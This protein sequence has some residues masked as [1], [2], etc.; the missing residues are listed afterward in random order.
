VAAAFTGSAAV[1]VARLSAV[2]VNVVSCPFMTAV[3]VDVTVDPTRK[4]EKLTFGT[5]LYAAVNTV[6]LVVGIIVN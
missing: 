3:P 2:A 1:D 6:V 5:P 4:V